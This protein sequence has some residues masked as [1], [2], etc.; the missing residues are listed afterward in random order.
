MRSRSRS[1]PKAALAASAAAAVLAAGAAP[2]LADDPASEESP[3]TTPDTDAGADTWSG[4]ETFQ[5]PVEPQ[6]GHDQ[7]LRFGGENRYETAAAVALGYGEEPDVVYIATGADFPDALAARAWSAQAASDVPMGGGFAPR[8]HD[9]G[10]PAPLL[11][12]R[13]GE[14]P[15]ATIEA[16]SLIEPDEIRVIGGSGAVSDDVEEALADYAPEVNRLGG[17]N[18]YD[19]AATIAAEFE[20]GGSVAFVVSGENYPD[21]LVAGAVAGRAHAPVL[22]TP[23]DRISSYT[24]EALDALDVDS[25]VVIGGEAAV[26]EV[27]FDAIVSQVPNTIRIAGANRYET[28]E[29]VADAYER[30]SGVVLATGTNFPDA[31][32]GAALAA[33][34]GTPILLTQAGP[35]ELRSG[36][37]ELIDTLSP[38]A[39]A[40]IGGTGVISDDTEAFLNEWAPVWLDEVVVQVLGL[41]D[42][43][44]HLEAEDGTTL[45]AAHDPDR[46]VVGGS[47][48]LATWLDIHRSRSWDEQTVT[49]AAGDLIGGSPFISGA[50]REEPSV[51][52]LSALGLDIS[53]VGNHEFDQGTDELL[54]LQEGGCFVLDGEEDC[55]FEDQPYDGADFSWLAANVVYNEEAGPELEGETVLP[56]TELRTFTTLTGESVDVGFIGMTLE[57]TPTLVS[58]GGVST[59]D[60]LEES[61][62]ANAAAE[63]LTAD[64]ADAVVVLLHEGGYNAGT[65]NGC[66]GVSQPIA[67]IVE[68]FDDTIDV[69]VTGHTHQPYVCNLPNSVG[70]EILVTSAN[71]YGRVVT[72]IRLGVSAA[73]GAVLRDRTVAENHL[74]T[75]D[76]DRDPELTEIVGKWGAL[77]EEI[78]GEVV[79]TISD[80]ITGDASTDRDEETSLGNLIADSILYGTEA[81]EDGGAEIAFMNIGG[82]RAN[83][84]YDAQSHDEAPGEVTYAE[85]R[86]V[87][88]FGNIVTIFD[89]SG[90]DI[91][92]VLEQQYIEARG[93]QFLHLATSEGLTYDWDKTAPEGEQI[94]N[95][96]LNGEP[97]DPD[98]TYRVATLSFLAEGG[99]QFTAFTNGENFVGGPGDLANLVDYLGAHPDIAPPPT[100][101]VNVTAEPDDGADG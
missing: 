73:D 77:G 11:L 74:V 24:T 65:Y 52:S 75:R 18:R 71:E 32:A 53:S 58:P 36:T 27:P 95:L 87:A 70:E 33:G 50:F 90:A 67:G 2:V 41:N 35:N 7:A 100:D 48:Y 17:V 80:D 3:E 23:R 83:L 93:R 76:V 60:F 56:G 30:D 51:E 94:S 44:G 45:S 82:I 98:Q 89:L 26:G 22:L 14:L 61:S 64:G 92:A 37:A 6:D 16:L 39:L 12:T 40:I 63:Q 79:G 31:L 69:V 72:D 59:V 78:A 97:I 38:Q 62:T 1:W 9:A 20:S 21:A 25:V 96:Q 86:A 4:Q 91:E 13:P 54:R 46:N 66:E 84:V 43:H 19:T 29:I 47:E 68:Q 88:P 5:V 99:D 8:A 55:F 57:D 49:V 28:A 10:V 34:A 81:P 101:R 42:Y 85:A 15:Q